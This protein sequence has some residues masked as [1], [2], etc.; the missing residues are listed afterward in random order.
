MSDI[1]GLSDEDV[2]LEIFKLAQSLWGF[3]RSITGEGVR[4]SLNLI[5][6][7]LPDLRIKSIRSGQR[8]FDWTVPKEWEVNEAFILTPSGHK[9]C[10]FSKNNLHL[11]GYSEPYQGCM[12]LEELKPHLHSIPS[13]P[14]A[15]P[16][17]TS[18]YKKRWG[19]CLTQN[20]MS[21][22]EEGVY[23]VVVDTRLFDGQMNYAELLV[24]GLEQSEV[25]L[26]SYICHPSMANNELSGPTVLTFLSKWLLELPARKYSYRIVF[27]PET[28]GSIAYIASNHRVLKEK[29]IAGF[30][31]SCVG[32]ER[33][34]S[35]LP[36]RAENTLSDKVA[37]HVLRHV[38][39]NFVRYSWLDRGSDERQYC[40]PGI[41]LPIASIMRTKYG[42]YPEYHTSLDTL[43]SVVTPK[44]LAGGFSALKQ[45]LEVLE[46][47]NT[48][49]STMLCEPQMSRRHLY[50]SI[51][52]NNQSVTVNLMMDFLSYCDGQIC[53]LSIAEKLGVPLWSLEETIDQLRRHGLIESVG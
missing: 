13:K 8:V 21:A 34:F 46:L 5:Q 37:L 17:V 27:V 12:T 24:P 41:D 52:N 14:D 36:S 15:I 3:N 9:I 23:E 30:N 51:S 20:E 32:D 48:Y 28:I 26:S 44:G 45:A 18:Y 6:K 43:G 1:S 53:A 22:L 47:N 35:F 38:A 19:F 16:Y 4:L 2:G 29:T 10:D 7:E 40:A 42:A 31:V 33:S 50:P 39:P 25:L 49:R 11:V